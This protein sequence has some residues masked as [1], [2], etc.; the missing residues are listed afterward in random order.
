MKNAKLLL[1][2][3]LF[4]VML[5]GC[6][7]VLDGGAGQTT[8]YEPSPSYDALEETY[9]AK[10][11]GDY[12]FSPDSSEASSDRKV[13]KTG[14]SE[15]EVPQGQLE[16]SYQNLRARL[17]EMGSTIDSV[18]YQE[19]D[20]S[21]YYYITAKVPPGEFEELPELFSQIGELTSMD[22]SSRDVT[23]QYED[24]ELRLETLY[25]TKD[26]LLQ[27][28]NKA[29]DVEDILEVERELSR[30]NYEIEYYENKKLN[31]DRKVA[32]STVTIKL[33]EESPMLES[34]VIVPLS[35]LVTA[36]FFA[37]SGAL[38]LISGG[39]GFF[40]PIAVIA[41]IAYFVYVKYYAKKKK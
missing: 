15:I 20:S 38:V 29:D 10:E 23:E 6:L 8:Y 11:S 18:S 24:I 5:F 19:T 32:M 34:N 33:Y 25:A 27:L 16:T 14:D 22:V 17:V 3:A 39:L 7:D 12:S 37:L 1:T 2:L 40:L 21:K 13:I 30:I 31:I 26:R 28:Y 36:F 4:G 9:A 41:G 35:G